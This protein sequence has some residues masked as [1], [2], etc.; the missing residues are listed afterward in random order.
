[1]KGI[2]RTPEWFYV[3]VFRKETW[4]EKNILA[5]SQATGG[6][7]I[8]QSLEKINLIS[9]EEIHKSDKSK[10]SPTRLP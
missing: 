4:N 1:L 8:E 9:S 5:A 7:I 10:P 2:L 6:H 3:Q